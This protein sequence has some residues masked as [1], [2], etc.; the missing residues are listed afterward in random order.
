MITN[1]SIMTSYIKSPYFRH[2][3]VSVII[4]LTKDHI[5]DCYMLL[6]SVLK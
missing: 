1:R 2:I 6:K 3:H 4:D 5:T